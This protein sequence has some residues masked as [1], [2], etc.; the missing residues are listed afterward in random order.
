MKGRIQALRS[1]L[2][3]FLFAATTGSQAADVTAFAL[4]QRLD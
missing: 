1:F 4:M 3:S 2:L